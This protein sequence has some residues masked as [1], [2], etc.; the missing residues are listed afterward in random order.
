[1]DKDYAEALQQAKKNLADMKERGEVDDVDEW[2][3]LKR[4]IFSPAEIDAMNLKASIIVDLITSRQA[5]GISQKKLGE[6][7]GV[8]QSAIA[9]LERGKINPTLWTLQKLLKP[10][11][12]KLAVIEI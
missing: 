10:L 1:M 6:L 11:G 4:E 5:K 8:K 3:E 12:K 7:S 9:R 2:A